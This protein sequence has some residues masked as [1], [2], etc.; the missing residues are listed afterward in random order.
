M[1]KSKSLR[2]YLRENY[3]MTL[4]E[5]ENLE[6]EKLIEEILDGYDRI[7]SIPDKKSVEG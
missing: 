1:M 5:Y 3:N 2:E 7:K 6:D 4:E